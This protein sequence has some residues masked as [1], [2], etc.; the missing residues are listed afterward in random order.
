MN[1]QKLASKIWESA[2]KMRSKI[3]ANE[4]KDYIL[5]FIF[6][7]FLSEKEVDFLKGDGWTDKDLKML[8]EEDDDTVKYCQRQL[9]YFIAYDNLFSTWI[10]KG[11]DFSVANVRDALSAFSRMI[12]DSHKKV[13][14]KIF[15][16]LQTG[17]S[18]LGDSAGSQTK[19]ISDLLQLIKAIPMDGKQ[20]YDVLGFIYE[21]LISNFAANAGKKAGEFYTPHE[22]SLLMSEIVANH[23]KDR[24]KIEICDPT[25]G[26][27][28]LLITIGKSA[29]KFIN[30]KDNIK[31]YAQEWKEN[32]YNLTRMNLVMR[33]IL[34]D[35][36]LARCGDTLEEDWPWFDDAD[37][38]RTYKPLYV[39]AVVSNP[40]YSQHWDPSNK[41]NDPRYHDF[42][43][44]PK[45]KADYA[46][47]LHDLYHIKPNGIMTIV[48][49]HGV[50]FR[51]G[52]EGEI[53]RKLIEKNHIDAIIGLPANIFFGTGIPTI[54]MVLKQKRPNTDVLII[55]ASKGFA[56]VGKTNKLQASDIKRIVDA[57]AGRKTIENF[58]RLVKRD[59]IRQNEYNLNIPRYVD[60]S[61]DGETWDIYATMFGGI[62]HAEIDQLTEYWTAFPR[63][64]EIL[65]T[66]DGTPY[67]ALAVADVK[68]AITTSDDIK[69]F[70]HN[71]ETAFNGFD[72]YLKVELIDK[73]LTVSVSNEEL[74]ISDSIFERISPLPL[75]DK[76]K[77]YQLLDDE[78]V[79][80]SID[81]EII[82][83]EGFAAT[84][85]VD[86]NM[87]S[88]KKDGNDE[89]VQDGWIGH[90]IPFELV[91]ASLL[92]DQAEE[93][94]AKE[95][96]LDDISAEYLEVIDSLSEEDREGDFLNEDKTAFVA[97]GVR[98][99][100][101]ELYADV[102]SEEL[103]GLHGYLALL[104]SKAGKADKLHFVAEH[105]GV[106]W[107]AVESDGGVYA[108]AKV[109]ER[110]KFLQANF[111]FPEDS[112]ESKMVRVETLMDEEK[113]VKRQAKE[114]FTA[115]H[116]KTKQTIEGL[117][118][119]QAI[120]LL[121]LKWIHPLVVSL[122]DIPMTII[123][124]LVKSIKTL[125]EKYATTYLELENKIRESE[126]ALSAIIDELEGDEYDMAGLSEFKKLLMG[127]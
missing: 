113:E 125:T 76:Y 34:P 49:P 91:Q 85:L 32:T 65:F 124:N 75:V 45:S 120:E 24:D 50:L 80:I 92:K 106:D 103:S 33:G 14:N 53:R 44:A 40:P 121:K 58:S 54:I 97:A 114:L 70:V 73:M 15:D 66:D 104:D 18:K 55:D 11:K 28:S 30:N 118:D 42:G 62:P 1:K 78:W 127:E 21:Y 48:L 71:F 10:E 83:T 68:E 102:E 116:K 100:V 79:K 59:E 38:A 82:Q 8:A 67:S 64:R 112:F 61:E 7:K 16:T 4:Y 110:I 72:A 13:F 60:S 98:A 111:T 119:E 77:A 26:S 107:S 56:K 43:L 25:S 96:R 9:G 89:E 94:K 63:L 5:G 69:A 41:E 35:N 74:A 2:N 12:S 90:V 17:L 6:Y 105:K 126:K 36:I 88:K 47:L 39:D 81:L 27:G 22:V 109:A 122:H 31:Y 37:R 29:S 117:S 3:E 86:P 51:G 123:N 108:K 84:K 57:L 95:R 23:L 19:A 20:D 115:L 46:F 93:V 101:A 99:K 52:E 87:V